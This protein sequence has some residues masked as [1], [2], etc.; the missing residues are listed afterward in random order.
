[1][2]NRALP[3]SKHPYPYLTYCEYE[4]IYFHLLIEDSK[5][6]PVFFFFQTTSFL[7]SKLKYTVFGIVLNKKGL[8]PWRKSMWTLPN[9]EWYCQENFPLSKHPQKLPLL[10]SS[11]A[12]WEH[13]HSQYIFFKRAFLHEISQDLRDKS[14]NYFSATQAC[15]QQTP[16]VSTPYAR[17]YPHP[18]VSWS[19]L[20]SLSFWPMLLHVVTALN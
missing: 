9:T 5:L 11:L 6:F 12:L 8:H 2:N 7:E 13:T 20:T 15:C 19:L 18:T 3:S 16:S 10:S 1:M 4:L 14:V 17:L